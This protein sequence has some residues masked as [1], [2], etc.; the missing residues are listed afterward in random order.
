MAAI[1]TDP[2]L[3]RDSVWRHGLSPM[4]PRSYVDELT[5]ITVCCFPYSDADWVTDGTILDTDYGYAIHVWVTY[6]LSLQ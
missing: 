3:G 4:G 2:D 1:F 6:I 5:A